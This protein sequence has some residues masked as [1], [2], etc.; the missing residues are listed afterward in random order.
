MVTA[1]TEEPL[2]S[3]SQW[4]YSFFLGHFVLGHRSVVIVAIGVTSITRFAVSAGMIGAPGAYTGNFR[5]G[6]A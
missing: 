4:H 5:E 3:E 6:G 2:G 1:G